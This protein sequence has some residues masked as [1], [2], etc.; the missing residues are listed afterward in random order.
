[1]RRAANIAIADGRSRHLGP[2][3]RLVRTRYEKAGDAVTVIDAASGQTR[4]VVKTAPGNG[5]KLTA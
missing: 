4:A 2:T 5:E 3:R 1:M